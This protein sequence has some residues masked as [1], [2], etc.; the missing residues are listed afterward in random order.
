M[1]SVQ[2]HNFSLL[3]IW[4]NTVS[5]IVGIFYGN[6]QTTQKNNQDTGYVDKKTDQSTVYS[7]DSV[8]I[9]IKTHEKFSFLELN[10][11]FIT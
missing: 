3:Q 9:P 7:L 4:V 5:N 8:Q 6:E 11:N 1:H 2:Q 10:W